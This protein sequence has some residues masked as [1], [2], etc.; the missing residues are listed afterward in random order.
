LTW[1]VGGEEVVLRVEVDIV[2]NIEMP[3][4]GYYF[5]DR[6]GQNL[7]GDN[8]CISTA[9]RPISLKVGQRFAVDFRFQMPILPT[10][11]YTLTVT[12]AEGTQAEH[13]QH[14]WIHD[15]LLIRSHSSSACTGLVGIPVVDIKY[16]AY[17]PAN[18][19]V[20]TSPP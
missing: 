17:S 13:V 9:Q 14:H 6:L 8:T 12:F 18:V 20:E 4:V 1:C 3:I 7:F 11:D 2:K 16:W 5:R 15:A 10:G 19:P